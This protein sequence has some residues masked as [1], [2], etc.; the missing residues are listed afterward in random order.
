MGVELI[1]G[2]ELSE[3]IREDIKAEVQE[4][5]EQ[6]VTPH[7]TVVLVG[8]N[9]ASESYVRGKER[10]FEETGMSSNVIRMESSVTEEELVETIK[11]LNANSDVHGILVQLPLPSHINTQVIIE[12]IDPAKDVDGFHP[13]NVGRMM[14]EQDALLPCTPLGVIELLESKNIDPEGKHAVVVGSS[15]I[16]GKPVGQLLLNREA[17]VTYCHIKTKDLQSHTKMADIL[18]VAIGSANEITGDY[19]KEDAVIIDVGINRLDDGTLTGDV[20]FESVKNK[21]SYITPVP[22]GVGPMTITM[23]LKNTVTACKNLENL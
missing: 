7:L 16:V 14:T 22:G 5:K 21:A 13:L 2:K 18:V 10:A 19:I 11:D 9:P 20:D 8:N 17:T 15:N 12:L 6:G 4:L 3:N 1:N 23:L